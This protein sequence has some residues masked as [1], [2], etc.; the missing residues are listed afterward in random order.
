ML[1]AGNYLRRSAD[2]ARERLRPE[3]AG[4][5]PARAVKVQRDGTM[6]KLLL[7]SLLI[8]SF[9]F[10]IRFARDRSA[11]RG[12]RRTVV[13]VTVWVA[14]YVLALLVILPRLS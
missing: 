6:R 11:V 12:L 13:G 9:A 10:P 14:L 1:W 4:N 2:V 5:T 7:L 8:A 3:S